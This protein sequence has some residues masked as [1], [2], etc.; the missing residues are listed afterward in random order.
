MRLGDIN[1]DDTKGVFEGL[2]STQEQ[3][4]RLNNA[5]TI[6]IFKKLG[7]LHSHKKEYTTAKRYYERALAA[8]KITL[9]DDDAETLEV[10]N[11]SIISGVRT[12]YQKPPRRAYGPLLPPL[13]RRNPVCSN[14]A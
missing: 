11:L 6:A 1:P 10:M 9:G 13:A 14:L 4:K 7:A 8:S 3:Y 12:P 5:G 2:Q